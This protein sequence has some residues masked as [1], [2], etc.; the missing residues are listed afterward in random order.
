V[1]NIG[2]ARE[3]KT[4]KGHTTNVSHALPLAAAI[5]IVGTVSSVTAAICK[6]PSGHHF[7]GVHVV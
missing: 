4:S 5:I 2:G 1:P 6:V 7:K 3:Q